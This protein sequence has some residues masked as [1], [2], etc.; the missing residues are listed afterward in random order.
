MSLRRSVVHQTNVTRDLPF[1]VAQHGWSYP[2]YDGRA[3]VNDTQLRDR[4]GIQLAC[5]YQ[6]IL[7]VDVLYRS[8]NRKLMFAQPCS[9]N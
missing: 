3:A 7:P 8:V 4:I 2:R 6:Q 5:C 9:A 1:R